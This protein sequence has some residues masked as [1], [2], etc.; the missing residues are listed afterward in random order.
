MMNSG[1]RLDEIIHTI[2]VPD[3]TLARP[4]LRPLYDEPEFVIRNIWRLY[5]GWWDANPARLKPPPDADL[6]AEVVRI[7]G[8]A[9]ELARRAQELASDGRLDV[10]CQL[11]EWASQAAP[12]DAEVH[13]AR[14]EVYMQRHRAASSLMAKGIFASAARESEARLP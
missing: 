6:A 3:E 11:V 10:A 12:D 8:G 1:A 13:R 14:A 5:G 2:R 4:Y 7:A 9:A